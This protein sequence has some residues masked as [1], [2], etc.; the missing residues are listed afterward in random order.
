[1][2]WIIS[3]YY[4]KDDRMSVIFERIAWCLCNRVSR[5][6]APTELFK[7]PFD[8]ILVQISNGKRLLQSWK[9][10]Y[11]ARRADI[12]ASGREYRWEFDKNLLF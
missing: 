12:E 9:S 2:I 6:L 8:D 5:M 10:T 3:P 11:M 7:I 4:S 1:M